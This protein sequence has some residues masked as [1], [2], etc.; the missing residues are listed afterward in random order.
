VRA[1]VVLTEATEKGPGRF[2][3]KTKVTVEIKD[4]EKPAL[5]AETLMLSVTEVPT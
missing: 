4:N 3:F 1:R 2:L 5:V